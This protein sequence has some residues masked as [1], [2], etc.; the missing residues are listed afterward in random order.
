MSEPAPS[1]RPR[2]GNSTLATETSP[3]TENNLA[4]LKIHLGRFGNTSTSLN[5]CVYANGR[6]IKQLYQPIVHPQQA[7]RDIVDTYVLENENGDR[8]S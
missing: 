4:V 7:W 8:Q 3:T 1:K 6:A 2:A 5:P